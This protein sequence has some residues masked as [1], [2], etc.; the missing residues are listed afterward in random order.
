M[1]KLNIILIVIFS[2]SVT[3]GFAEK[4]VNSTG[5]NKKSIKSV[6]AG[7]LPPNASRYLQYNN[8]KA[9]VHNGGDMWWDLAS[10]ARYYVPK[11]GNVSALFAGSIWVGGKDTNGQLRFAGHTFR[12]GGVDFYPG[13][14][15][16]RGTNKGN[17]SAEICTRYDRQ[18]FITKNMVSKHIAYTSSE[19]P[20]LEYPDYV[21]PEVIT[22]WPAHGPT[23]DEYDYYLA[24]FKDVNGDGS[25]TP[26]AG[27]YPYYIFD[28]KNYNCNQRPERE[29]DSLNNSSMQLFGDATL[30]WVY[31]DR[32]G[33]HNETQGDPIGM[34]FRAQAFAFSTN[35]ELNNMTFY[36]YQIINRSSF[37]LLE[38]YFGVWTDA[39]M[40]NPYDDYVGTDVQ[41][42]LGYL[43]NGDD[44]DEDGD[45][46]G[47]GEHPPAIGID[48]FEGP[49]KDPTGKDDLSSY[50]DDGTLYCDRGFADF[51][52]DGQMDTMALDSDVRFN[53]NINGLNFG[54][55]IADNERWGMRSFMYYNNESGPYGNPNLAP[56][57]YKYITG[58][59][60]NGTR[61]NYGGTGHDNPG[62][63]PD[64]DIDADFMFPGDT[65]KCW[66]GTGG[67]VPENKNWTEASEGNTPYDRRFIQAA[68]P[69]TLEPGNVND[70]TTGAVWARS[71]A[72]GLMASV[73]KM[74]KADDKAQSLFEECFQL[75]DGPDAPNLTIIPQDREFIVHISNPPNSNNYLEEYVQ[76]DYLNIGAGYE[77][78][79][80]KFQGYQVYQVANKDVTL[81]QL[82]DQSYAKIV[83]QC[84]LKDG[85]GDLVNYTYDKAIDGHYPT[86]M[87][88]AENEGIRHSFTIAKDMFSSSSDGLLVNNKKYYYVALAY[89]HNNFKTYS[90]TD[91]AGFD[92]QKTPYLASRKGVGGEIRTYE[93]IPHP[94]NMDNG[95]TDINAQYGTHPAITK[96][97]GMG[98]GHQYVK[99]ADGVED[100]IL[101]GIPLDNIRYKAGYGPIDIKVVNPFNIEG[102][103]YYVGIIADSVNT[104]ADNADHYVYY[105][106]WDTL[107]NTNPRV[108]FIH[109]SKWF[110]ARL[111]QFNEFDTIAIS[112]T[113]LSEKNEIVF[114]S[115]GIS[116]DINQ[117]G[118]PLHNHAGITHLKK[119]STSNGFVGATMTYENI[120]KPWLDFIKDEEGQSPLN[121][122]RAGKTVYSDVGDA[123]WSDKNG[124]DTG[125][126]YENVLN[127]SWA[128]RALVTDYTHGPGPSGGAL[129]H[130]ASGVVLPSI[131]V[132]ITKDP[133]KWT[134]V[135]V[136]EMTENSKDE[137]NQV[138]NPNSEGNVL[139]FDLRAAPSIDKAYN[140]ATVDGASMNPDDANYIADSGWSW[141]PGYAIDVETGRRLNM[142]FGESSWLVGYN[143]RD[144]LWNP[145]NTII[146]EDNNLIL[147]GKHYLYIF[148]SDKAADG[149]YMPPYDS[150]AL[151]NRKLED[152]LSFYTRYAQ[153]ISM[154]IT[155]KG[156]QFDTYDDMPDN[157]V[158]IEIRTAFPFNVGLGIDSVANPLNKNYPLYKFN[159]DEYI[160]DVGVATVA[161]DALESINVV[162][163][164]Y[165]GGNKYESAPLDY[166]VKITNL[167]EVCSINIYNLAGTLIRSFEKDNS[168]TIVEWD[169]KNNY[170]VPIA[171]G[172]YIIH[173]E[174]P[175]VGEKTLKWFGILRPDDLSSF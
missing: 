55:G 74:R 35:D 10:S 30:W 156:Y 170:R 95:G 104:Q 151:F 67:D 103:T 50:D 68:G 154:P 124:V 144:M 127:R 77:D 149:G 25:Y 58:Y 97:E 60:I 100:S 51:D 62:D 45:A 89:A 106:A 21:T 26:G 168:S 79:E 18:Y 162:P 113:W 134:R 5:G 142:A 121:W 94:R 152:S 155:R 158:R 157:D 31:N 163:N 92:G 20:A 130:T 69:F 7:C 41:R 102:G 9:M 64:V 107:L 17:V 71:Y 61:M 59:W 81:D 19:N 42:G 150:L 44:N 70:I 86:V 29:A 108:G 13:P 73:D 3:H 65:D 48:F 161:E 83:F 139:K 173:V 143:G 147:G 32:G 87:V 109:D 153:W 96:I 91:T 15:V 120:D 39:D 172:M 133:S 16:A 90:Q 119:F 54:D 34:E 164:P 40:G 135:P 84:D 118:F 49:Y 4:N 14:L 99:L 33:V 122:I 88:E 123:V 56:D 129:V 75:I 101:Q 116:V 98:N 175:D 165:Y 28:S 72:G 159:M 27:D 137:N 22:N 117:Y 47:Y 174:V 52:G 43:Y 141:F 128:P 1:K 167:P 11:S 82:R 2:L 105:G 37:T 146:S 93:V 171:G 132:V 6:G 38:A 131:N 24:P 63:H 140:P 57:Y 66:W 169:L 36:N 110:L 125:S 145:V 111:N 8:V 46:P 166:V 12:D 160:P 126:Y 23:E 76:E 85:I 136:F 138:I 80:Y 112:N 115:I 78:N 114:D 53:G 148:A